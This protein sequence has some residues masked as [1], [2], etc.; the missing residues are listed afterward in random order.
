MGAPRILGLAGAAGAVLMPVRAAAL[1]LVRQTIRGESVVTEMQYDRT[2]GDEVEDMYQLLAEVSA[3][4][5]WHA[6]C[7]PH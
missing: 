3:S 4:A 5:S 7:A 2:E 1:P 6:P